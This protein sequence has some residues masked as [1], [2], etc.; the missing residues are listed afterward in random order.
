[1]AAQNELVARIRATSLRT[2]MSPPTGDVVSLAIGEPDF[3]TPPG[4]VA[5]MKRALDAG[6]THYT[7]PLGLPEL[8]SA[9]GDRAGRGHGP[10]NVTIT[11]GGSA[12]L[13][14]VIMSVVNPGD[15][16]VI[17]DPTYSLYADIAAAAGGTA[18]RVARRAD[19]RLDRERLRAALAGAALLIVCQPGNPTGRILTAD[20]WRTIAEATRGT[21]T[22]VLS[23]EAYGGIV[24]GDGFVS[25]LDVADLR[26]RAVLCQTFSKTYAMTGWRLGY[27]VGP[28]P[29]VADAALVHRTI[30]G[31]I[32]TAAQHAA[33][34][35]F[36]AAIERDLK[37]MVD[38]YRERRDVMGAELAAVPRLTF[39][40]PEGGF[41]FYCAYDDPRTS[42]EIRD[43]ARR[44]GVLIRPGRE[45]GPAGEGHIRLSFATSVA[46][47]E[48]GVRRLARVFTPQEPPGA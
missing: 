37:A 10:D 21:G 42:L 41:Y 15:T 19:G 34:A 17:D 33:L 6:H 26:D 29:V 39:E 31:A 25:V 11:H 22:L 35:A 23:D 44:C 30:N 45:F 4:I 3:A 27:L 8:R 20:E 24:Y 28:A 16:V 47:I 9:I 18:V 43:A 1:M 7:D 5:A 13:A 38:Q 2:P 14:A 46:G 40:P 32:N 48:R 12:G 36:D